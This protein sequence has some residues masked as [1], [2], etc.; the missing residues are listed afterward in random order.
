MAAGSCPERRLR[1]RRC[2][3]S[4]NIP[5]TQHGQRR[6]PR[7][8]WSR[9]SGEQRGC[10]C[11]Q[12]HPTLGK[13]HGN[14]FPS[15]GT[16]PSHSDAVFRR[17]SAQVA[18]RLHFA[19]N[20]AFSVHLLQ[21]QSFPPPSW[22]KPLWLRDGTTT[23]IPFS[24][25]TFRQGA[26]HHRPSQTS[27]VAPGILARSPVPWPPSAEATAAVWPRSRSAPAY[28][29]SIES[30]AGRKRRSTPLANPSQRSF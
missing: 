7:W 26:S 30:G 22:G 9:P 21:L 17:D 12:P 27:G 13:G 19:V 25:I 18:P 5:P 16:F 1:R 23:S 3:G 24:S 2:Q 10:R 20:L 15:L 4:R 29:L 28:L 8:G 11:H 6:G 14:F